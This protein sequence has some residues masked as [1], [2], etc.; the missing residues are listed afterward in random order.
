VSA[1][2]VGKGSHGNDQLSILLPTSLLSILAPFD[3]VA[4]CRSSILNRKGRTYRSICYD[5]EEWLE[6]STVDWTSTS[7]QHRD[8]PSSNSGRSSV[9]TLLLPT[10]GQRNTVL[11]RPLPL[12]GRSRANI[13][14]K[15][16]AAL[17]SSLEQAT[18][19]ITDVP[20]INSDLIRFLPCN[21]KVRKWPNFAL[22]GR[23]RI[24]SEL[25]SGIRPIVTRYTIEKDIKNTRYYYY[26]S[27]FS[28]LTLLMTLVFYQHF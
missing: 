22:Y 16:S 2:D 14:M 9:C 21:A 10:E 26:L 4:T 20:E 13:A 12:P 28:A 18:H 15:L 1:L 5:T 24:K 11:G 25:I 6:Q 7:S 3:S 23:N 8:H 17:P 27:I 19:I